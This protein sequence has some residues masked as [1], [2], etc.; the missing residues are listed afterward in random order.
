MPARTIQPGDTVVLTS[1]L[2]Q[3]HDGTFAPVSGLFTIEEFQPA[4][5]AAFVHEPGYVLVPEGVTDDPD[6]DVFVP[7]DAFR[8][9]VFP[10]AYGRWLVLE[11]EMEEAS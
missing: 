1:C 8:E 10:K 9:Q 11:G 6:A 4:D 3:R 7:L 2:A 5:R